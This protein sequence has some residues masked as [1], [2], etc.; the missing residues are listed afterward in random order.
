MTISGERYVLIRVLR[1]ALLAATPTGHLEVS[2]LMV[3]DFSMCNDD[4]ARGPLPYSM[5]GH[6][7]PACAPEIHASL[8][9]PHSNCRPEVGC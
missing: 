8:C 6:N 4:H 7:L 9:F 1:E 2:T 3:C 5:S